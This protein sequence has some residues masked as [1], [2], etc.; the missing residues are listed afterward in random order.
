M[1]SDWKVNTPRRPLILLG[2]VLYVFAFQGSRSLWEPDEGRYTAVALEMGRL[3]DYVSPHLHH[4]VKH[5][6]K[7]PLTYWLLAVSVEALGSSE[8]ALR[9][10]NALAFL[11]TILLVARMERRLAPESPLLAPL[12]YA[13][14]LLPFG[15]ANVITTDTLLTLWETLAV[16]GFVELWW[17]REERRG[18]FRIV[19]WLSFGLAFLT[20]GPPGLLPLLAIVLFAVSMEGIAGVRKLVSPAGLLVFGAVGLSWYVL[21]GLRQPADLEHLWRYEVLARIFSPVHDRNSS[22]YGPL[23]IYVPSLLL[24]TLP[25]TGRIFKA[26]RDGGRLSA[27]GQDPVSFFLLSWVGLSLLVFALSR[28]RMHLYVLPLFVPLALLAARHRGAA[29]V[30]SP[31]WRT[32]MA[33]WIIFLVALRAT[34]AHLPVDKDSRV[35]ARAIQGAGNLPL[36]EVVFVETHPRYGLAFYLGAEVE[37]VTLN[38]PLASAP[39]G[40]EALG[41]ELREDEGA[42]LFVVSRKHSPAFRDRSQALG[43]NVLPRGEWRG[44]EFYRLRPSTIHPD[45]ASK[46]GALGKG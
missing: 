32:G 28:S 37:A 11:L 23:V 44:L 4:E 42:R 8:W 41:E 12:V 9:T 17:G 22:W 6:S 13:T 30:P 29:A 24:G 21:L 3:G 25:W 10:P 20:K 1:T 18:L 38:P 39:E 31:R 7:P 14:C 27:R 34:A 36:D 2:L 15:A 35:L 45:F 5:L 19:L 33:F 16:Y 26:C 43:F 40:A 46:R